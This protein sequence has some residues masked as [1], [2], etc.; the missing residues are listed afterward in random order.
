M[1]PSVS[2]AKSPLIVLIFPNDL[3]PTRDPLFRLDVLERRERR[4][5]RR[6]LAMALTFGA[7]SAARNLVSQ[8]LA[9]VTQT[10]SRPF[11]A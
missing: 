3:P 10:F 8:V 6:Q 7:V 4:R 2:R 9:R 5:F 1:I 11:G